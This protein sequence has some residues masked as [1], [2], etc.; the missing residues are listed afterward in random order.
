MTTLT[1]TSDLD[2]AEL[3]ARVEGEV[4][5]PCDPG[6]D[7]A[8][9]AW[10]LAADQYPGAVVYPESAEDV[11]A[12]VSYARLRGYRVAPQGTGHNAAA[13]G[14]LD[15]ETILLKTERM[16]GVEVDPSRARARVD[17]GVIWQEVVD[18]A[19]E[20]GL[21]ALHGSSHDVGVVGYSLGGGIG[22]YARRYGMAANSVLAVELVTADGSI[23]RADANTEPELFWAVRGG[24][25]SFGVVTALE[26]ALLPITEVYAGV[27]FWPVE[28]APEV[29]KAYAAW[30]E[31][32]PDEITSAGRIM[33]F[34]PFPS[35]PEPFRGNT[36]ALVE[37]AALLDDVEGAALVA[38]LRELGP[39]MDT[40]T[41]VPAHALTKLHM[42]PPSP[43]PGAGDGTT[44]RELTDETVD[45]LVAVA[46]A[47]SGS[48]LLSVE[49]RQLGGALARRAPG[50]GAAASLDGAYAV[51]AVGMAPTPEA[52]AE[53]RHH[54]ERVL[55]ALE[56]WKAERTYFNFTERSVDPGDLHAAETL[57]RLRAVKAAVDPDELFRVV[58][59]IA[60][61]E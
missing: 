39:V 49:L 27:L 17:A 4:V 28:R 52:E 50:N 22:W 61:A 24:G 20:H 15:P 6:W 36:F 12:I 46:G 14:R 29:L 13:L 59:P 7:E 41:L 11:A 40:M 58:H 30:A 25:G 57:A 8:R 10:N 35:I 42:D 21:A 45:A 56:P 47:D 51:F 48:P 32:L 26:I 9:L 44:I 5:F 33:Q 53:T 55:D 34:P 19:A 31:T 16:R 2:A 1:L 38:P 18:A 3:R 60:P 43:V 23:V 37:V 54:V